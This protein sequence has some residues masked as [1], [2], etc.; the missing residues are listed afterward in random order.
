MWK[1]L[2]TA[3]LKIVLEDN[4]VK[5]FSLFCKVHVGSLSTFTSAFPCLLFLFSFT[6]PLY[7]PIEHKHLIAANSYTFQV[8]PTNQVTMVTKQ[9]GTRKQ[10]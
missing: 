10:K 6:T 9:K 4:E 8:T 7:W 1:L 3:T 5:I 2:L